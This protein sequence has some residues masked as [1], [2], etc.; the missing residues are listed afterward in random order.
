MKSVFATSWKNSV[1]RRKQRKYSYNAPAHIKG[2]FLSSNLS[3]ALREKHGIRS[4][5]VKTG[6]KVRIMRGNNK[7]KEGKIERVDIGKTLIYI[8]GIDANKMDGSKAAVALHPSSV[9][10]IDLDLSDKK[11]KEKLTKSSKAPASSKPETATGEQ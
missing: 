7:G 5:R 8:A 3:K 11:R 9:M 10:I 6:D 2:K 1:Q 4:A